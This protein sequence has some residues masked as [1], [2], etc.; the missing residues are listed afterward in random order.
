MFTRRRC[1]EVVQQFRSLYLTYDLFLTFS[2]F[3]A[4]LVLQSIFPARR[5]VPEPQHL[6]SSIPKTFVLS[7]RSHRA[8]SFASYYRPPRLASRS[9]V[10]LDRFTR[11]GILDIS[12]SGSSTGHPTVSGICPL[13]D[14]LSMFSIPSH[15]LSFLPRLASHPETPLKHA[16]W[17]TWNLLNPETSIDPHLV[18]YSPL[19]YPR[20]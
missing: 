20:R 1:R 10:L 5:L 8:R 18:Y 16:T 17:S 19:L 3:G 15:A 6:F 7:R 14:A 9:T 4:S 2:P 11:S 13:L 12:S